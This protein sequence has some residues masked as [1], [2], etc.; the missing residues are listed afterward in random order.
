MK[1]IT[2]LKKEYEKKGIIVIPSVFTSEECD[3]IKRQAYSIKDEE[4]RAAGY[5]HSPSETA[6]NKRSLIFF[7]ALANDYI[8]NIRTDERMVELVKE[9]IGDDVR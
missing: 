2:T 9:F 6:Y 5:P 3:E 7:P 8:N 1:K 4:I